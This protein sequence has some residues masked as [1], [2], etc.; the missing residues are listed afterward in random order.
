MAKPTSASFPP[1][2]RALPARTLARDRRVRLR[3]ARAA[4]LDALV[5]INVVA[6]VHNHRLVPDV[7]G[8]RID[9]RRARHY[10]KHALRSPRA[11]VW[12]AA[13]GPGLLGVIGVD[14][15]VARSRLAPARRLVY[16]HSLWVQPAARRLGL[17]RALT[18][19]AMAWGR[20]L[21]ATQARLEVAVPN[22]GARRLYQGLG[23]AER[24]LLLVRPI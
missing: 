14:L 2:G 3:R 5:A 18:Q 8:R 17:G 20:R 1:I 22:A 6:D 13:R 15:L 16:L 11:A 19:A 10:W 4:D 9:R 12:V 7:G 21:G 24:E 23:F